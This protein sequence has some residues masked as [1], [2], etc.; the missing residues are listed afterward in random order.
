MSCDYEQPC[1]FCIAQK[2]RID[3][4]EEAQTKQEDRL[5][6]NLTRIHTKIDT[7]HSLMSNRLP[8]WATFAIS[9]LTMVAGAGIAYALKSVG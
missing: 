5:Y 7:N 1:Q 2:E 9:F 4:V 6:T 3:K 8:G